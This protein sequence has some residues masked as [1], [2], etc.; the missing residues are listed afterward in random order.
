M[1]I[2]LRYRI[3]LTHSYLLD[4]RGRGGLA[5]RGG[6]G[7]GGRGAGP[8]PAIFGDA[9][10]SS[11]PTISEPWPAA[12]APAL[13]GDSVA[14]APTD[15]DAVSVT[16]TA[17]GET[18]IPTAANSTTAW[19]GWGSKNSSI[20]SAAPAPKP[21]PVATKPEAVA[22]VSDGW[23][24]EPATAVPQASSGWG[25]EPT[26]AASVEPSSEA[27]KPEEKALEALPP[28]VP[29]TATKA[30]SRPVPGSKM[31]WAQIARYAYAS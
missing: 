30:P 17:G 9:T 13:N 16:A 18:P 8:R 28:P 19:S 4:L 20:R 26:T 22:P 29:V 27:A 24:D 23:G 6:R 15:A 7:G 21:Q 14:D 1:A 3:I 2:L 31:S 11:A 25:D 10:N 5:G 12:A